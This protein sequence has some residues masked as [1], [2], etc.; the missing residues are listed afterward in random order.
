M[1][2]VLRRLKPDVF[3]DIIAL[4]ALYRPG[5]MDQIPRYI[6][7][8]HGKEKPDYLYPTLEGILKET[9]GVMIYQEQVMQIAQELS[10]FTLGGADLLRRAMG[11]KTKPEMEEQRRAFVDGAVA[12]SVP[13]AKAEHIFE[14]VDKFAGYG[15]NKS[16]AAAYALIA[17]QTAY[18]KANHPV[19]FLAASMT[20]DMGNTD[21]LGTFRQELQRL[22]IALLP[23]DVN[24]SDPD[25]AVEPT[26]TGTWAIRYALGA[27]RNVGFQAMQIL[28]ADRAKAGPFKTLFD[29][30][31]RLDAKAV[32]KRQMESLAAAGAFDSLE[33]SRSRAF[34]AA[35][36][37]VQI[38]S[39]A[40]QDRASNQVS[41]FG[42]DPSAV[43]RPTL[44][45]APEWSM[46]ERLRREFE[47]IGF[48]LSAH[49]L[50]AYAKSLGRLRVINSA[51]LPT[52]VRTAES[53]KV[54]LAG[55][56]VGKKER[57]SAKGTR[58]AFVQLSDMGGMYEVTVFSEVLSAAR[59][60][61]EAGRAV[62]VSAD[63]KREG[64]GVR[65]IAQRIQPLDQAVAGAAPAI[66][67]HIAEASAI[68]VLKQAI[69]KVGRG[70]AQVSLVIDVGPDREVE[71]Q[72]PGGF[73]LSPAQTAEFATFPGVL[74]VVEV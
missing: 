71:I 21:K 44:P 56:I 12:R 15:F 70:K 40:A 3:E 59:D 32:N 10:G 62:L 25:F 53:I 4:V 69:A 41:L 11:K 18:L 47:A 35:E 60:L 73:A 57:T 31:E 49:P 63:A 30:S 39:R 24:K 5:P 46:M 28:V 66:R 58:F 42:N 19:E 23:P 45:A 34:A 54:Q 55:T 61:L 7:C 72:V 67:V 64:E 51:D 38:A 2:D 33:P 17:Y 68:A 48:Y 8:K 14:Q 74:E 20:L 52:R 1:R 36:M 9:F 65:M 22:G 16:H 26:A 27:I 29:L 6:A 37:L 43:A 13:K 50:D